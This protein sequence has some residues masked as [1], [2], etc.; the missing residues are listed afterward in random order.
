MKIPKSLKLPR[1]LK[2]ELKK[3]VRQ[4][5][6]NSGFRRRCGNP[7]SASIFMSTNYIGSN[8]RSFFRLCKVMRKEQKEYFR[9]LYDQLY[10]QFEYD[11]LIN[12]Y[13]D[14][15]KD[16]KKDFISEQM[17]M[18]NEFINN[19]LNHNKAIDNFWFE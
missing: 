3:G 11:H 12:Q 5:I 18:N 6:Y 1:K 16:F 9:K 10:D 8:T 19:S 15:L 14:P 4:T 2:K 17:R 13:P 7:F